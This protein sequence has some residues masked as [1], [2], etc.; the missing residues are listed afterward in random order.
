[1]GLNPLIQALQDPSL[2]D[3]PISQFEIIETH[4]SLVIL[5]GTFAYKIKKPVYFPFVDFSTLEKRLFYCQEELRLN[6]KLAPSLYQ[7]VLPISGSFDHPHIGLHPSKPTIEYAIKMAQF[8]T[9]QVLAR[10]LKQGHL[11]V[12]HLNKLAEQISLFHQEAAKSELFSPYGEPHTIQ[13]AMLDNFSECLPLLNA[14]KLD[15]LNTPL[16][17]LQ[18]WSKNQFK[19]LEPLF[20][21]RK[22]AGFI[23][24]CHGDLHLENM[25][26]FNNQLIIFDCIEFNNTLHWIDTMNDIAFLTMDLHAKQA[27]KKAWYFLNRYLALTEDFEGMALLPFYQVY[28]AMVRAKVALLSP[29]PN[30]L[31][32]F[33]HYLNLAQAFTQSSNS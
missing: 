21:A 15:A 20:L 22:Q 33:S 25:V 18:A 32:L 24:E 29:S 1:M 19:I 17:E 9:E 4:L 27:P 10:L 6:Q 28:R 7:E 13:T 31:A 23:R 12:S 30:P 14:K 16:L 8:D 5:T 26:L 3:H 2:Y 11:T